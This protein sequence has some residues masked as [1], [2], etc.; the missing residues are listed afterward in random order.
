[1][2]HSVEGKSNLLVLA[3]VIS[4]RLTPSSH[5]LVSI[6][7][8]MRRFPIAVATLLTITSGFLSFSSMNQLSEVISFPV[9]VIDERVVSRRRTQIDPLSDPQKQQLMDKY[10]NITNF[11]NIKPRRIGGSCNP[12]IKKNGHVSTVQYVACCG[13]GHRLARMAAASHVAQQLEAD[14]YGFWKCC[15]AVDVF[16]YL[17]GTEP[18]FQGSP[19]KTV[20][21]LQFR[22]EVP[23]FRKASCPCVPS[24]VESQ[25]YFYERLME[26]YRRKDRVDAFVQEHFVGRLSLGIHI[27][28]GNGETGDFAK[29]KRG[30]QNATAFVSVLSQHVRQLTANSTA[31]I[32]VATDTPSYLE[33]LRKEMPDIP[34]VD[35]PQERPESGTGVLFGSSSTASGDTCLNGWDAALQDMMLLSSCD[36]VLATTVSSFSHTMPMAMA[37]GRPNRKAEA[38]YC[39]MRGEAMNCFSDVNQWCCKGKK[40]R[41]DNYFDV[42]EDYR[43]EEADVNAIQSSPVR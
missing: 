25:Y 18:L 14:L 15:D 35:L 32:F 37:L 16:E 29:K 9:E 23:G 1:M 20:Y 5:R 43:I 40:D 34:V 30:I 27:R 22:N 11:L 21:D 3:S 10:N 17:F 36:M 24:R 41:S 2:R 42:A 19:N 6:S 39:E 28:A 38:K 26:R 13:L 7:H 8:T 12:R 33:A 31:V 4:H